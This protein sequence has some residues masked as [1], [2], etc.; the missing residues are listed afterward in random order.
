[1]RLAANALKPGLVYGTLSGGSGA[2]P[3]NETDNRTCGYVSILKDSTGA[4]TDACGAAEEER[5]ATR[6]ERE[7]ARVDEAKIR[8]CLV[9]KAPFESAWAGERVCRRCKSTSAW[10]GGALG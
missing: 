10:R 3:Q 5:C 8:K 2:A 7:T 9:C 4:F 1:M 6:E